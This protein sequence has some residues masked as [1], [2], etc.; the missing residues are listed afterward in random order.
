M[1]MHAAEEWA[2]EMNY[3][4]LVLDVFASNKMARHFYNRQGF[5]EDSMRLK[6]IE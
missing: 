2:R 3:L 5:D 1:L 6:A 4:A